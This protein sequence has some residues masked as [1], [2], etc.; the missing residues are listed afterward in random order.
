MNLPTHLIEF[1]GNKYHFMV[2]NPPKQYADYCNE[3][4]V[5]NEDNDIELVDEITIYT[6]QS[7]HPTERI[8]HGSALLVV[9]K[10]E[11]IREINWYYG[12]DNISYVINKEAK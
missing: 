7:K 11:H 9:R 5:K 1:E 6:P 4:L 3:T 10:G 2:A 8:L 12:V